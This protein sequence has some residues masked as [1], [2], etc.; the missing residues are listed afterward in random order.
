MRLILLGPPGAGKGTQA[1]RLVAKYGI[2]QLSTGDMLR[3]AVKAGTPIGLQAQDIMARGAL[4]PDDVVVASSPSGS[5][6]PM[7]ARASSSTASRARCRRPR[8]STACWP[9]GARARRRDRAQGRRGRAGQAHRKPDRRDEGARRAAARRRQ[10]RGSAQAACGLSRADRAADRLL[11]AAGRA[12]APWTAWRRSTRSPPRSTRRC[13]PKRQAR[14]Q[15]AQPAKPR[16]ESNEGRIKP[17]AAAVGK[18]PQIGKKSEGAAVPSRAR[19]VRSV[20]IKLAPE[21]AR[22]S[23]SAQ[24]KAE[25][26]LRTLRTL[27]TNSLAEVDEGAVESINKPKISSRRLSSDA[28]PQAAGRR[29]LFT[30]VAFS[31]DIR[32]DGTAAGLPR[33]PVGRPRIRSN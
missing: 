22:S 4:V 23:R 29:W 17:K 16:Q 26:R 13:P 15:N 18:K 31:G 8:R 19:P 6:S 3:A 28:K 30:F 2:V 5:S 33:S 21:A 25:P 9:S 27:Y 1:Q 14:R 10:S 11:P 7:R 12:A 32:T 20:R 24:T